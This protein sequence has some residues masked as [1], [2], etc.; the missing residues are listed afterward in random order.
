MK[1]R[2]D[3]LDIFVRD[4]CRYVT[5]GFD[6]SGKRRVFRN[7]GAAIHVEGGEVKDVGILLRNTNALVACVKRN[8]DCV[9]FHWDGEKWRAVKY[10]QIKAKSEKTRR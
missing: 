9:E 5:S 1:M 10:K 8:S 2:P 7:V 4:G 6:R 3:V